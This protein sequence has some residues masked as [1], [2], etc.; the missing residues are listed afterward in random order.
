MMHD[1]AKDALFK[2]GNFPGARTFRT[3]FETR[4]SESRHPDCCI[5]RKI[6]YYPDQTGSR[7]R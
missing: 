3:P 5:N 4:A 2:S 6:R 1:E 7:F